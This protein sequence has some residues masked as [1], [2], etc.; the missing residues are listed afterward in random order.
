MDAL[1]VL[2]TCRIG[3]EHEKLPVL[4]G[5]LQRAG[6]E[7]IRYIL[8]GLR[9][10][11]GWNAITEKGALLGFFGPFLMVLCLSNDV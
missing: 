3:T 11:F 6:Y 2:R 4:A 5:K 1:H 9:D 7:E 10:R 8:E